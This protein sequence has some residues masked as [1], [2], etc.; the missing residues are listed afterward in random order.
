MTPPAPFVCLFA[1]F[2]CRQTP[3]TDLPVP[4]PFGVQSDQSSS[5][6]ESDADN[7]PSSEVETESAE[8]VSR[9][10]EKLP[11]P[12]NKK[13]G[14]LPAPLLGQNLPSG[15]AGSVFVNPFQNA[16]KVK[17]SVLEK[18]V[19]MTNYVEE[20]ET[21]EKRKKRAKDKRKICHRFISGNC[22]YGK[23]CRFS[24]DLGP[25]A[26]ELE[27]KEEAALKSQNS[28]K[29]A[30]Y[31]NRSWNETVTDESAQADDDSYMAQA[32]RKRRVGVNDHLVPPKKAMK[33]LEDQRAA[34]RPWTVQQE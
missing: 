28:A 15:A 27:A 30:N 25:S 11:N 13:T 19:K 22:R 12:L 4:N 3:R 7:S 18:H 1:V 9:T 33:S 31:G 17:Q 10:Q 29:H 24:H 2:S 21:K 32:K 14:K 23:K 16:E 8:S 26:E 6:D 34:E 5:E 20:E